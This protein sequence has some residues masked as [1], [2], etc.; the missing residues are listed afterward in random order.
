MASDIHMTEAL[1]AI[2]HKGETLMH[3]IFGTVT[4][5]EVQLFAYFAFTE[6][7]FLIAYLTS[8]DKITGTERIPLDIK[9]V[10]IKKTKLIK[11]SKKSSKS[12]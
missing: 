5:G 7:H 2:L 10:K 1:S 11:N 12:A 8:G 4:K 6:T 3:P 9:S